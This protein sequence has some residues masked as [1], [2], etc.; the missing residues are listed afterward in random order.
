MRPPGN[1]RA[2][3][4][5]FQPALALTGALFLQQ[6]LSTLYVRATGRDHTP[7]FPGKAKTLGS[8][9]WNEAGDLAKPR[10]GAV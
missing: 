9:V 1:V 6:V 8:G 10:Q 3:L 7:T 5:G 4:L 2:V